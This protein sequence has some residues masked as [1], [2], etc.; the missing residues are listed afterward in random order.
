MLQGNLKTNNPELLPDWY[1]SGLQPF[2]LPREALLKH[3]G[4]AAAWLETSQESLP[5]IIKAQD[6]LIL[7]FDLIK[8]LN[9]FTQE[10]YH[11]LKRPL[12]TYF[13]GNYH[14]IP[15]NLRFLINRIFSRKSLSLKGFPLWPLE[16]SG[17]LWLHWAQKI[18]NL[19][20]FAWK[21]SK[22]YALIFTHDVDT[23]NGFKNV[24]KLAD[25]EEQHQIKS[26]WFLVTHHYPLD[27]G[28]LKE[29]HR[30]GHELGCHSCSHDLN[31]PFQETKAIKVHLQKSLA[32]L[33]PYEPKGFRSPCMLRNENFYAILEEYFL[34]DSSIPDTERFAPYWYPNGCAYPWPFKKNNLVILPLTLSQDAFLL[35]LGYTPEQI[36]KLWTCKLN[37]IKAIGGL[38]VFSLHPEKHF[39]GNPPMF[40]LYNRLL[41][42]C[43]S[44]TEAWRTTGAELAEWYLKEPNYVI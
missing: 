5:L 27:H 8:V 37:W 2:T 43:A 30:Q 36:F 4:E 18:N 12:M 25:I 7:N 14:L 39:S 24:S 6:K 22:K 13:P 28:L 1:D 16:A 41:E 40:S 23:L 44:D 35:F 33:E 17:A 9:I 15:D 34:Y 26:T 32:V 31:L 11:Q 3:E 42:Y 10:S 19:T 20:P 21:D 38:A 29:L